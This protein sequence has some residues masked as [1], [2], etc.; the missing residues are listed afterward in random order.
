MPSKDRSVTIR[1]ATASIFISEDQSFVFATSA[2]DQGDIK[3]VSSSSRMI[4][5]FYYL[6][7]S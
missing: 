2:A 1:E 7:R 4:L 5:T 3:Q 6:S